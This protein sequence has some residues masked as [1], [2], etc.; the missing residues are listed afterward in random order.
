M[1]LWLFFCRLVAGGVV[2][3]Q[4]RSR[5]S[6]AIG[7]GGRRLLLVGVGRPAGG[8]TV[9]ETACSPYKGSLSDG[10]GKGFLALSFSGFGQMAVLSPQ[11]MKEVTWRGVLKMMYIKHSCPEYRGH[12]ICLHLLPLASL[13]LS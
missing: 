9:T 8:L 12:L 7:D 1:L 11:E 2:T 6:H 5:Y 10:K 13:G 3:A 4:N